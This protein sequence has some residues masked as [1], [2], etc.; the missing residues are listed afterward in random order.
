MP[1]AAYDVPVAEPVRASTPSPSSSGPA[2]EVPGSHTLV[3][4]RAVVGPPLALAANLG[5]NFLELRKGE[6]RR[7]YIPRTWVN[8]G[9]R[10]GPELEGSAPI[11]AKIRSGRRGEAPTGSRSKLRLKPLSLSAPLAVATFSKA[12]GLSVRLEQ[13]PVV[14][15]GG[16]LDTLPRGSPSAEGGH[17]RPV[18]AAQH[19]YVRVRLIPGS[20]R[21]WRAMAHPP[22]PLLL[23]TPP[24]MAP[25]AKCTMNL[26]DRTPPATSP[27]YRAAD[28][29]LT[30]PHN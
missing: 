27:P 8:K 10:Q 24:S 6:V 30:N 17:K 22:R 15:L 1:D 19:H 14:L 9:T 12:Q 26:I 23:P 20:S 21:T 16:F 28:L 5:A 3:P 4:E 18:L 2:S 7:I 13:P 25:S 29:R 11:S